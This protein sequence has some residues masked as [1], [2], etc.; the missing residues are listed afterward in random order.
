MLV[1]AWAGL[2]QDGDFGRALLEIAARLAEHSTSR[3]DQ[4][5]FRDKLAFLEALDVVTPEPQSA[6]APIVFTLAEKRSTP[7]FAPARVKLS[8]EGGGEEID[9]ETRE[10]IDLTPARLAVLVAADPA[11]DRIERAPAFVTAGPGEEAPATRYRLLSAVEAGGTALQLVQAVG[12]APD[13]LLRLGGVAYRV[14]TAEGTIVRLR[15]P[16]EASAAAGAAVEKLL[17]LEAFA[18]RDIQEHATYFAHKELL[19]LDGPAEITL[20][21]DPPALAARLAALDVEYRLWGTRKGASDPAWQPLELIGAGTDG[22]RLVKDWEGGVDELALGDCKSRWIRVRLK[23]PIAGACGPPTSAVSAA[24]KVQSAPPKEKDEGSETITAASYNGQPLATS[25]AFFP[26]GPEPQRFDSFALSAPEALTKKGARVTLKVTLSDSSLESMTLAAGAST[27]LYGVDRSGRL[28]S[29][30]FAPGSRA[31]WR[32][33]GLPSTPAEAAQAGGPARLGAGPLYALSVGTAAAGQLD[34][35]FVADR[36]RLIRVAKVRTAGESWAADP[37]L[38]LPPP[39]GEPFQAFCLSVSSHSELRPHALIATD[40]DRFYARPID[41]SG[42]TEAPWAPMAS[43]GAAPDLTPPLAIAATRLHDEG[44]RIALVT[45]EGRIYRGTVPAALGSID[46]KLLAAP[47]AA[48]PEVQPA[49]HL[50]GDERLVVAAARLDGNALM[51][52]REDGEQFEPP[53]HS[54]PDIGKPVSIRFAAELGDE[55]SPVPFTMASGAGGLMLWST[56]TKARTWALPPGAD[57]NGLPLAL[58]AAEGGGADAGMLVLNGSNGLVLH[59]PLSGGRQDVAAHRYDFVVRAPDTAPTHVV[60][61]RSTAAL[62]PLPGPWLDLY[63]TD[64]HPL[65][66]GALPRSTATQGFNVDLVGEGPAGLG[67]NKAGAQKIKLDA[68]DTA[69]APRDLLLIDGVLREVRTV[70]PGTGANPR[71]TADLDGPISGAN[72]AAVAYAVYKSLGM[73]AVGP[74]SG[75]LAELGGVDLPA[76]ARELQFPPPADPEVQPFQKLTGQP[77]GESWVLLQEYWTHEPDGEAASLAADLDIGAWGEA[78]SPRKSDNPELSWEYHDGETWERLDLGFRDGTANL[79]GSGEIRFEVPHDLSP[80][81]IGGKEDYWIRARLIGGDYGR[82]TYVVETDPPLPETPSRT[83]ITIDRSRLNP[84]EILAIEATYELENS[85]PPDCVVTDNNLAAIDQTQAAMADGAVFGLF[86]G[87]VEHVADGDGGSRALYLGFDRPPG[88]AAL[89]LYAN[90]DDLDSE[91]R[92]LLAETLTRDGWRRI[93]ARDE[94]AVLTRPGLLRLFLQPPPE[95]LPLFGRDGWWLRLRPA[96]DAAAWAPRLRS[97]FVNAVV[98]EHARSVAQE[99]LGSSLGEP[100]QSY[101]LAQTPVLPATLE[102]RVREALGEEER[103]AI[104]ALGGSAAVVDEDPDLP[105]QW[106]LWRRVQSFVDENGDSRVYRLDPASGEVRFGNGRRGKIPPAGRDSI[107]A[108]SYQKGGGSVGNVPARAISK[109]SSAIES[110]EQ[111]INPVDSAGGADAPSRERLEVAAPALLRHGGRALAPADVEALALA[112]A[113]DVVRARCLPHEGCGIALAVAIRA[114]DSRCPVPTRARRE[115]IAR[116]IAEAGWGALDPAAIVVRPPRYVHI[117][118]DATVL[119]TRSDA[120]AG[121]EHDVRAAL[122]AFLHPLEG[123][124]D[125]LG[126]PFGRRARANDL[127]RAIA[128]VEGLDRVVAI[129]VAAKDRDTDLDAMPPDS[130]I[131]VEEND[132]TL[133]VQPPV[134]RR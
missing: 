80:V 20:S 127:Q 73:M 35:V 122:A 48:D 59:A 56:P 83:S 67:G 37:W 10:A 21:F 34:L 111:A 91:A 121:V 44:T 101:R 57:P 19:K 55:D 49:V 134:D 125:G 41:R 65:P 85:V 58:I 82:A 131:C 119:A 107:R 12:V 106:V 71:S 116:N 39:A 43:A 25:S 129:T 112:S 93:S 96:Q 86:E 26:F 63:G 18:M 30:R 110:V 14:E 126:W 40:G 113:P 42:S 66:A 24:L 28:Q 99:I 46:W 104:L 16:L 92:G 15:D 114:T 124:P 27:H 90:A 9:F 50:D 6:T 95:Q 62:L 4:T 69:T 89:N 118:V 97:L 103:E 74:S 117:T 115:G 61:D 77:S 33:L 11:I 102:L 79:A 76:R 23:T 108:F 8:A 3:L 123:G 45:A 17:A 7:V 87:M 1:P 75:N 51:V 13:D 94:T 60:V 5:A 52:L 64:L 120:V 105:G 47:A 22:L 78:R 81:E 32:E 53:G 2:H 68:S 128:G 72:N 133:N 36:H 84:P 98:A 31:R 132:I 100:G 88:V 38:E 109:L 130:L 70:T 29:I 54:G